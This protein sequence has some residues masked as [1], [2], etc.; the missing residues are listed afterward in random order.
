ML[1]FFF[2]YSIKI[3]SAYEENTSYKNHMRYILNNDP[4]NNK[5]Q[6]NLLS[7]CLSYIHRH[8]LCLIIEILL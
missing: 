6:S 3:V 7:I 4:L 2:F 8:F 5:F 1:I